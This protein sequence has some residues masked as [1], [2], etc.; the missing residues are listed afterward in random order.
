MLCLRPYKACDAEKIVSWTG[1]ERAF[2]LWSADRFDTFPLTADGLNAHYDSFAYSESQL[3]FTL[4]DN[5][6]VC[7]HMIMRYTDEAR[8][9]VRFGFV[10]VD[11]SRR[12]QGLGK[13]ML[14]LAVKYAFEFLGA[15]KLT[16]GVFTTNQSALECYK[17]AGFTECGTIK[18]ACAYGDE[19]W[20]LT[21]MEI[22]R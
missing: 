11:N 2:R 17:A 16:L 7:G 5:G 10:I 22:I 9:T 15:D 3:P 6:E 8:K 20:D 14:T 13:A 12:G 19:S 1:D 18:N 21:E 4:T